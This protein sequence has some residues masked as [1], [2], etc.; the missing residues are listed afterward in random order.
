MSAMGASLLNLT[1]AILTIIF[2][3]FFPILR[4]RYVH[5]LITNKSDGKLVEL[6]G[7]NDPVDGNQA[8]RYTADSKIEAMALEFG[9]LLTTQLESQRMFFQQQ[10]AQASSN[11]N[12][13]AFHAM[14]IIGDLYV[15]RQRRHSSH[16]CR[17]WNNVR[18]S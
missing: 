17:V 7:E 18:W 15:H 9:N 1:T 10:L 8:S 4:R 14:S 16:E 3:F 11:N 12:A 6:P 13:N 2:F 5:R